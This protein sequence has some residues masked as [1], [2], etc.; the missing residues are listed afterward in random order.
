MGETAFSWASADEAFE[1]L[2]GIF[3]ELVAD[4]VEEQVGSHRLFVR[5][6]RDPRLAFPIFGGGDLGAY[7]VDLIRGHS[8]RA[9]RERGQIECGVHRAEFRCFRHERG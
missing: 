1:L 8:S 9:G 2:L 6:T 4:F 3:D 7:F 5:Q